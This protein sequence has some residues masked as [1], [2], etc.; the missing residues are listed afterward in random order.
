[1]LVNHNDDTQNNRRSGEYGSKTTIKQWEGQE[2]TN[3]NIYDDIGVIAGGLMASGITN[4]PILV[5]V[6]HDVDANKDQ[7]THSRKV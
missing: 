1:V 6:N 4:Q 3:R 5:L 2:T 7:H